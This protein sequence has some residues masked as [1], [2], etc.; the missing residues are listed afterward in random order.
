[1]NL[2]VG[3]AS[4]APGA[5]DGLLRQI[6][7]ACGPAN[8]VPAPDQWSAVVVADD[9]SEEMVGSARSYLRGG[10]AVLCS[11]M[12]HARLTGTPARSGSIRTLLQ[13]DAGGMFPGIGLVD[14]FAP[15]IVPG[16]AN[17]VRSGEGRASVA[18]CTLGSGWCVALPFDAARLIADVRQM[19]KSFWA[20]R[21]RL[22]FEHLS[23]VSRSGI[24]K[25]VTRALEL[26][27]HRRGLPFVHLWHYPG[28][29]P[30]LFAFRI[31]TDYGTAAE[32]GPLASLLKKR[33]IHASWFVH[34]SGQ[35]KLLPLYAGLEG[36]EIGV[37]CFD[38]RAFDRY[39]LIEGDIAKAAAIMRTAGIV[40]TAYAGPYGR[41]NSDVARAISRHG[42]EFSSEFAYDYDN[43]PSAP[44]AD[45]GASAT[46][47][48]PVHPVSIGSLRRQGCSPDEMRGYF[49]GVV[50]S[51]LR[52]RDPL[53]FYHH[54]KNLHLDVLDGLFAD[55]QRRG[56]RTVLLGEY[57]RWWKRRSAVSF[58][59]SVDGDTLRMSGSPAPEDL[60]CRLTRADGSEAF[61]PISGSLD[62]RAADWTPPP[63]PLALPKDIGRI[64]AFN[65]WI[66]INR[67][68]DFV[69]RIFARS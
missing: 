59:P 25:L 51:K 50:E 24:R 58:E 11:G 54:P 34:V 21:R 7:V 55:I 48:V 43:L 47:Q 44:P 67:M 10:G 32:V 17:A 38:H 33:G 42:F 8:G 52:S 62:L 56:L 45:S 40:P 6:G 39:D 5:W 53:F 4:A 2:R 14:L 30:T 15:C 13:D 66:P 22:P 35:E 26:L 63:E 64:R 23:L 29:N 18:V 1:M 28:E 57:A 12:I 31:D 36:H 60:R 3:I 41:W 65:P 68:E 9:A 46:L 19:H 20:E 49:A 16:G 27:H 69:H 37:H 61:A